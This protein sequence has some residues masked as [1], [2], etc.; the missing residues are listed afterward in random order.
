MDRPPPVLQA[1]V[2]PDRQGDDELQLV[3][4]A[5]GQELVLHPLCQPVQECVDQGATLPATVG[6]QRLEVDSV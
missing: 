5:P 1:C 2:D 6:R 3:W 4:Q